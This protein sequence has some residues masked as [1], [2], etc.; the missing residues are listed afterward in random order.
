MAES[1]EIVDRVQPDAVVLSPLA[2]TTGGVE[3]EL[4]EHL[5]R[6]VGSLS[7]LVDALDTGG[8]GPG[9]LPR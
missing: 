7:R 6:A 1:S 2:L 5:Q 9:A 4:I 8:S 3:L